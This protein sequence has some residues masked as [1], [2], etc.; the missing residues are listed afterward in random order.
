LEH[1]AHFSKGNAVPSRK[2]IQWSQLRVGAL[3]LAALAVLVVLIF[4]M[5]GSSGGPFARK[6]VLRSYFENAAG[7]KNGAPVTLEGVTIGNVIH[8]RVVPDRNPTPVEVTMQVGHEYL[9]S[10]H[11]TSTTSIAQAGVL[12]DSFVDIDSSHAS[13]PPPANNAELAVT[14]SPTIQ[15]VIRNS[16]GSLQDATI[17]VRKVDT[18]V[19]ALNSQRGTMGKIINDPALYTKVTHIAGDLEKITGSIN[20][21]K[22]TLGK[23]VNDDT[24]YTRANSA[25]DR[26]DKIT[27]A[28]DEGKGSAGKLLRDD[29]LYDNLNSAVSNANQLLT[30]I[31][32]GK[33]S[34]GKLAKDPQFAQKLDDTVTRLDNILTSVDEGKG[35]LG[36]LVQNRALYDHADQTMDQTQQLVKSI[37][38][39]P[40]KYLVIRLKLF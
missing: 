21:G 33:G 39:D 18:L 13:G 11:A 3:V 8:I 29:T 31:N 2:E 23:L 9:G 32:A 34:M 27:T 12:G 38:E 35:S 26:L 22:G 4:L 15:D 16:Q 19:D 5:S 40:K 10:L 28:L 6:L 1:P 7:L 20:Q 37:R 25:I 30:E 17:L 14:G 36:Q 24:L